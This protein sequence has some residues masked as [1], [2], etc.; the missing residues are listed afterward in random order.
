MH[1]D[2]DVPA[3][4][5]DHPPAPAA[6]RRLRADGGPE[7][8]RTALVFVGTA[9]YAG[10]IRLVTWQALRGASVAYPGHTTLAAAGGLLCGVALASLGALVRMRRKTHVS[11]SIL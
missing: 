3:A 7:G 2:A 11:A 1:D 5:P 8:T 10:L 9:A 4:R 6:A